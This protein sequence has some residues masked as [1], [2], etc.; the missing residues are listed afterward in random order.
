M[1]HSFNPT[2]VLYPSK[3]HHQHPDT[4]THLKNEETSLSAFI[5][6]GI[7][8]TRFLTYSH[9]SFRIWSQFLIFISTPKNGN[10]SS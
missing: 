1:E 9:V 2:H 8:L 10:F 3:P 7:M 5:G 4:D 6:Y